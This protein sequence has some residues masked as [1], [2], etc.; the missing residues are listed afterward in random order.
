LAK[1]TDDAKPDGCRHYSKQV[2]R[3]VK[4]LILVHCHLVLTFKFV[5]SD[6]RIYAISDKCESGITPINHMMSKDLGL[7]GKALKTRP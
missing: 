3:F 4:Y 5:Y 1:R 2:C 7:L 6:V